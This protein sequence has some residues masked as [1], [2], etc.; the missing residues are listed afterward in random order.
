M[1]GGLGP[2]RRRK[3]I[4]ADGIGIRRSPQISAHFAHLASRST[5]AQRSVPHAHGCVRDGDNKMRPREER[6]ADIIQKLLALADSTTFPAEAASAHALAGE[7]KRRTFQVAPFQFDPSSLPPLLRLRDIVRDPKHGYPG[8][9]PLTRSG[10]LDAVEA[11]YIPP[12][13]RL[14]PKAV[15]WKRA[16]V[17][18]VME[19]G[20]GERRAR[21]RRA[22]MLAKRRAAAKTDAAR[23]AG[24]AHEEAPV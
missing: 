9:V 2:N 17:L 4:F 20:V 24:G 5:S 6:L 21:G 8:L 12:P 13:V 3:K 14:G 1:R 22:E 7:L 11:G 15:A 23:H 10:W 19:H 18:N 16:D